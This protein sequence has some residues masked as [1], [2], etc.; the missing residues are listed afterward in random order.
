MTA[1]RNRPKAL[2]MNSIWAKDDVDE[3]TN[4]RFIG[5]F[6]AGG[7]NAGEQ[8]PDD[9][10][11]GYSLEFYFGKQVIDGQWTGF[12]EY[13]GPDVEGIEPR[14]FLPYMSFHQE[15]SAS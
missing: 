14:F 13:E 12:Y 6:W 3:L 4:D 9:M 15:R 10:C 2:P 5:W 8:V 7:G 11:E 1:Y